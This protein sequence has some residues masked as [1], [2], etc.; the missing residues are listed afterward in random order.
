M[1]V[2]TGA[3]DRPRVHHSRCADPKRLGCNCPT[4]W[5]RKPEDIGKTHRRSG[6]CFFQCSAENDVCS[7]S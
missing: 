4:S 1:P 2:L 3:P 5:L 6:N 7:T